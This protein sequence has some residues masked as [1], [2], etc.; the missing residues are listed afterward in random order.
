MFVK[1][2]RNPDDRYNPLAT[3]LL[4]KL[5][6]NNQYSLHG[7]VFICNE[8]ANQVLD[9]TIDDLKYVLKCVKQYININ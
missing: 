4:N 5:K 9:F 3:H 2:S 1:D 8:D 6:N 7:I